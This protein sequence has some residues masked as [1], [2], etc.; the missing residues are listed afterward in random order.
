MQQSFLAFLALSL[1]SS[2]AAM[3]GTALHAVKARNLAQSLTPRQNI[4]WTHG[5]CGGNTG[6][7]CQSG[8]CCS[9][10]GYCGTGAEY[11]GGGNNGGGDNGG[12]NSGG[13]VTCS[14]RKLYQGDGSTGAGWPS[15]NA[16]ASFDNLWNANVGTIG[17][18]CTQFGQANN[19]PTETAQ[20]KSAIQS[21]SSA[22]GVDARFILAV[23]M[24]ESKGCVRVPTTVGS[25]PN[26]GLMQDHNG[27]HTC[28]GRNPCPPSEIVGMIQEGTQGTSSGDGLQQIL[29]RLSAGGAQKFYQAARIYNSGSLPSDGNLSNGGATSSY[30]SDIANRLLGCV[31]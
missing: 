14:G 2:V 7:V 10:Y 17:I 22:S 12:G 8:Y 1:A 13:A 16:W 3:P 4:D 18:S 20:I 11:C 24:Q 30:P 27:V 26:P 15:I 5:T 28:Y 29:S 6:F 25:H 23:V 31:F 19:S 9:Q 21:V